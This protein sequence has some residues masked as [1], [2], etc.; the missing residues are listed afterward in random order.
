MLE[1][2][3]G[4]SPSEGSWVVKHVAVV[5]ASGAVG[6]RM[7]R[8]LEERAFPVA[9]SKFLASERSAGKTVTFRGEDFPIEPIAEG[10]FRGVD[11]V[12]SSTP[13]GVS[14]H[15]GPVVARAGA[16]VVDISSAFR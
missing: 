16:V 3:E 6:D 7:I 11:I 9:A 1:S 4:L 14:R 15:W 10:A 8:L 2:R 5:G 12:L 13:G